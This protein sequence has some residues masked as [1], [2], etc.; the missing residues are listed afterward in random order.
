VAVAIGLAP[1]V[2][3]AQESG[4]VGTGLAPVRDPT[5]PT[6]PMGIQ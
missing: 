4:A 6:A 5:F 3:L 2:G 1:M